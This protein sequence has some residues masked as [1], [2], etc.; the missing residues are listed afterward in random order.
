[1]IPNLLHPVPISIQSLDRTN[2]IY[3]DDM[4]EPVQQE[5]NVA[6]VI[7]P[8][9]VKWGKDQAFVPSSIGA[10]EDSDGYVLFRFV[11]LAAAGVTLKREDRFIALGTYITDVYVVS[12][13]PCGHY[14][15]QGGP[16]LI[17]A[18][19]SDRQPSRQSRGV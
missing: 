14:P 12:L 15:D 5:T 17:K 4:R 9:Q 13:Q 18:F 16:T 19:F 3:D 2:T 11:D 1:M 10:Q 7:V 6:T 8:G